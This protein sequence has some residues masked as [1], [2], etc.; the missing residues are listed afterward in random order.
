M[1]TEPMAKLV[2]PH[3]FD[4][5]GPVPE[6]VVQAART[7]AS[8]RVKYVSQWTPGMEQPLTTRE[9]QELFDA[10]ALQAEW[11][12]EVLEARDALKAEVER[13]RE[14]LGSCSGFLITLRDT[15]DYDFTIEHEKQI[16]RL[17]QEIF[18]ALHPQEPSDE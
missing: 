5:A 18:H 3:G 11:M 8:L 2:S 7:I 9:L 4:G 10:A 13:L 1:R 6:A 12:R 16:G 14:A 15:C 17:C